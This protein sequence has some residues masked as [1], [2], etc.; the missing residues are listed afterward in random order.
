[1]SDGIVRTIVETDAGDLPFQEYFVHQRCEPRVKGFHFEGIQEAVPAPGVEE[2]IRQAD[3]L[4]LCP[5]NP[6]VSIAPILAVINLREK[7]PGKIIVAV[8]PIIGGQAL[9]G[10]A[11]KMY[12]EMGIE[13]SAV[14]VARHYVPVIDG[15]ILDQVDARLEGAIQDLSLSSLAT[16]TIMNDSQD[17]RRLAG[18]VLNFIGSHLS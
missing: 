2:S 6:W 13:P 10:P 15:F 14:A 7:I 8:S 17:R 5:S 18:D 9:K 11:A 3:A 16:N 1:M 12:S 4:V